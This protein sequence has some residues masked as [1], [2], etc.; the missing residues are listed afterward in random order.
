ME[1]LLPILAY[2]QLNMACSSPILFISQDLVQCHIL[3]GL[4]E[5]PPLFHQVAIIYLSLKPNSTS[6]YPP[7]FLSDQRQ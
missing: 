4:P 5:F 3:A 7:V 6:L 1:S 2:S